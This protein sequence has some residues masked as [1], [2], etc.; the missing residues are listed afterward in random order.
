[1][2]SNHAAALAG[3]G[4]LLAIVSI[5]LPW[6]NTGPFTFNLLNALKPAACPPGVFCELVPTSPTL[7]VAFACTILGGSLGIISSLF[8]RRKSP[9]IS[10]VLVFVSLVTV[11]VG[12]GVSLSDA[13]VREGLSI[14]FYTDSFSAVLFMAHIVSHK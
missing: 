3:I 14:G 8:V 12:V 7:I 1:M 10:R 4:G 6:Y 11:A 9:K 13:I 2:R 5:A